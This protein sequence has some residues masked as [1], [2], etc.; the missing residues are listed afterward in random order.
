MNRLEKA[1]HSQSFLLLEDFRQKQLR[2][3]WYLSALGKRKFDDVIDNS[4]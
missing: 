3:E 1:M 4:I 2:D